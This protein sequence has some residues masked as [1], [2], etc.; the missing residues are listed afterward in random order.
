MKL[1]KQQVQFW[2]WLLHHCVQ[3]YSPYFF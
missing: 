1:A 2:Y 3:C